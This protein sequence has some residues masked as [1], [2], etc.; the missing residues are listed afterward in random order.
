[1]TFYV[2]ARQL[3]SVNMEN[4]LISPI[5]NIENCWISEIW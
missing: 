4:C 1:M 5:S 2:V 3:I